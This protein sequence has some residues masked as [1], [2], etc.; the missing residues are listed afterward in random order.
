MEY[1]ENSSLEAKVVKDFD[2]V[3]FPFVLA[4]IAFYLC[5]FGHFEDDCFEE[6]SIQ[7]SK[8]LVITRY[9]T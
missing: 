6:Y 9:I 1:E 5:E 8:K 4:S 3:T 7:Y 2:K